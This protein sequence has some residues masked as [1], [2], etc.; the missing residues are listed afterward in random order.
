MN[1][2]STP[3]GCCPKIAQ[4]CGGKLCYEPGSVCCGTVACKPGAVC[5]VAP[6]G[7]NVCCTSATDVPC[8]GYCTYQHPICRHAVALT[9]PMTRLHCRLL[10]LRGGVMPE[11]V[12]INLSVHVNVHV[13]VNLS[14]HINLPVHDNL[15]G[16]HNVPVYQRRNHNSHIDCLLLQDKDYREM[17]CH[18]G[19]S[20]QGCRRMG[21]HQGPGRGQV[22]P[23]ARLL[24]RHRSVRSDVHQH[25]RGHPLPTKYR[26]PERSQR[27]GDPAAQTHGTK[28]G[29]CVQNDGL[30]P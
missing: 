3:T 25:V 13:H 14:I 24:L 27:P 1:S 5:K 7:G 26:L 22:R 9:S 11:A 18:A 28:G 30:R 2:S 21:L 8:N 17:Q 20:P 4:T 10:L 19:R 16:R 29:R 15:A 23:G 12:D 6:G